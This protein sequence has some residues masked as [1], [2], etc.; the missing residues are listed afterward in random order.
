MVNPGKEEFPKDKSKS[1]RA[2]NCGY[3]WWQRQN[4]IRAI[5]G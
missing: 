2:P 3:G 1:L 5:R 4:D